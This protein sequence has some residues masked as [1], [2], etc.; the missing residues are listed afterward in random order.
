M[1]EEYYRKTVSNKIHKSYQKMKDNESWILNV[2]AI[3]NPDKAKELI[4]QLESSGK[5]PDL[6]ERNSLIA[7]FGMTTG[8]RIADILS[9]RV[10]EIYQ[11]GKIVDSF[12]HV[13]IKTKHTRQKRKAHTI[14]LRSKALRRRL[15]HYIKNRKSKSVWLFP[16]KN[17]KSK[18]SK[19]YIPLSAN[20]YYHIL[21]GAAHRVG[22]ESSVGTHTL[23]KT[24]G[25][26]FYQ[27]GG[28]LAY[29]QDLFNHSNSQITIRYIDLQEQEITQQLD[30]MF[31]ATN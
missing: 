27:H 22:I 8:M 1:T 2:H 10:N 21:N 24:F 23:R 7:I 11:K 12:K 14:Y 17:T 20:R 13:D 26:W 16:V 30:K 3:K 6:N 19:R 31:S 18:K 25:Y 9:L 28:S 29:L 4:M 5:D 15:L